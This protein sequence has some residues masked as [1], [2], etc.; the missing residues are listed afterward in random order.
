MTNTLVIY[1]GIAVVVLLVAAI[2][3]GALRARRRARPEPL[4]SITLEAPPQQ[5]LAVDTSVP[6][7][8]AVLAE[9]VPEVLVDTRTLRERLVGGLTKTRSA[10]GDRL[11]ILARRDGLDDDDWDEVEEVLIK[12]DLGVRAS[13]RIVEH[14]R[15]AKLAPNELESGLRAELVKILG[16]EPVPL[17][18]DAPGPNVWIV[19]GV[20]GVGKTTTIAKLAHMLKLQGRTVVLAAADTFRAAAIDQLGT[21]ADRVGVHM[22]K[23]AP[24]A[25]PG[26]V[27]FDAVEHAKARSIDVVI[28][29]TAG[30]LHTKTNLME[31]LRKIKRIAEREAG[32]VAEVL[33]VLDATVGQNGIS[34]AKTFQEAVEVT[35][36]VLT[37]LDGTARGGIVVAVKED[38]GIP[39]KAVGV[40]E[41]LDDLQ[42]FDPQAFAEAL[43][44]LSEARTG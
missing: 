35:G 18:I 25:D 39:V 2:A 28:V 33:L 8:G 38:L 44:D 12:A 15:E 43:V 41:G 21:W 26:A 10:I 20:N 13:M 22:V 4:D 34:Q 17:R 32:R 24:G 6:V 16:R 40:G 3:A 36:V 11:A 31:E 27:V 9:P 30:R 5:D 42:P 14:L 29:D 23:H 37:K 1:V 7:V 19:A